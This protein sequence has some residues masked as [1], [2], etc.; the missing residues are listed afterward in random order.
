MRN[1]Q[2][3]A[4]LYHISKAAQVQLKAKRDLHVLHTATGLTHLAC[5]EG[6]PSTSERLR[7]LLA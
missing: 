4:I 6:E 7:R 1:L 2:N 5:K 3:Q